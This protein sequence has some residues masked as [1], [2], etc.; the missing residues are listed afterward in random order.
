MITLFYF[1]CQN[2]YK[3]LYIFHKIIILL[4]TNNSGFRK[5]EHIG[6]R[7][8]LTNSIL[9]PIINSITF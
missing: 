9:I 5:N 7:I 2:I 4:G 8:H 1:L 6:T 3:S